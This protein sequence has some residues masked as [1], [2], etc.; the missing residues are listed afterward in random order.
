[1]GKRKAKESGVRNGLKQAPESESCEAP[2][3]PLVALAASAGG[4]DALTRFFDHLAEGTGAAFV[5]IQHRAADK[6]SALAPLLQKHTQAQ[7]KEVLENTP[8]EKDTVYLAPA[9]KD[10]EIFNGVLHPVEPAVHHGIRLPANHFLR[11]LA[12]ERGDQAVCV[13]LSG[14][15]DDGT[16]GLREIKANNGLVMAQTPAQA[17]YSQMPQNAVDTGLVDYVLDVES[18]PKQMM[19]YLRHPVRDTVIK[20]KEADL[21]SKLQEIFGL[22]RLETGRDFSHYKRNTAKR[23]IARRLAVHQIDDMDSYLRFLRN[24]R[25]EVEILARELLITVTSFFRNPQSFNA[26]KEKAIKEIVE[27]VPPGSD[28]KVW[29]AACSTGEEAYSIAI[30]FAE[31][32]EQSGKLHNVRIFATDIEEALIQRAREGRYP[33]SIAEDVSGRR[34]QKYFEE[35]ANGYSVSKKIRQMIIFSH[36]DLIND[37]VFS[38]VDL[39]SCRNAMIYFDTVLQKKL[40]P[41]FHYAIRD[42][43]Y[44]FLGE[45]ESVGSFSDLF[46]VVDASHKL[47]LRK[48]TE[49]AYPRDYTLR[50]P[51][52][53]V[54][55]EPRMEKSNESVEQFASQYV[56]R[57]YS[58]PCVIVD[59]NNQ[60]VFFNGDTSRYLRQP[61]GKPTLSILE[62]AKP[63]LHYTIN[64]LLNRV[65]KTNRG[66]V[67]RNQYLVDERSMEKMDIVAN[68][69]T[70]PGSNRKL[71]FI[72]FRLKSGEPGTPDSPD[73]VEAETENDER[74][75]VMEQE[76]Q[77]TKEHLQTIIEELETSNEELKSSNEELMSTNEEL[78][79]TNEELDTSRIELQTSNAELT[80]MNRRYEGKIQELGAA[81]DD[82]DNLLRNTQA[83]T[84]FL[85]G[86]LKI[87][88]F[89]PA[90]R[91]LFNLK[92]EDIAR[93][94]SD[95][96][97]KLS[98][99]QLSADVREVME[100]LGLV[101]KDIRDA[102]GREYR[103]R[104]GPYRTAENKIDGVVITLFNIGEM[105]M[106][107]L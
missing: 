88:W 96:T 7:V 22:I 9:D 61:G 34:L 80:E 65:R 24:N 70:E 56:L 73:R 98:Y 84:I 66:V 39:L 77:S 42:G 36:H 53:P 76:L 58:I 30:L 23:R 33:K 90:V 44:L 21:E 50:M 37:P 94:L 11:S 16:L 60:V 59:E 68:P 45:S 5:V 17:A 31:Q 57:E 106:K 55:P 79:S 78:Q 3:F 51:D 8:V 105:K 15:G 27:A 102:V 67:E 47:F 74:Y 69:I 103:V 43:R 62:M 101:E 12:L 29:V 40:L 72:G 92:D 14:S 20:S 87:R 48:S 1:M 2:Q 91:K 81:R 19:E 52:T 107:P 93:P 28:V 25:H 63:Q 41:L 95:I 49:M 89:T 99:P 13:I 97:N 100:H 46:K 10:L 104:I 4:L 38:K 83:A 35:E 6:H 86:E 85:N 32:M 54:P 71:V 18:I 82:L 26:L 75:H 64:V